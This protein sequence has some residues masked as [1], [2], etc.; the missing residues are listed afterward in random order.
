[1]TPPPARDELVVVVVVP[2]TIG[3]RAEAEHVDLVA[4]MDRDHQGDEAGGGIGDLPLQ[5]VFMEVLDE[6]RMDDAHA[7]GVPA[8]IILDEREYP[9]EDILGIGRDR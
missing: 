7:A 5:P 3:I 8:K 6:L 1:V 2:V 9:V 4:D